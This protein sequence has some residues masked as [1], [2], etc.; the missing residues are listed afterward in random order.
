MYFKQANF[1]GGLDRRGEVCYNVS[2]SNKLTQMI[3]FP[4]W[5]PGCDFDSLALLDFFLSSN[6]S[7]CSTVAFPPLENSD[8][9]IS[10]SIYCLSNSKGDTSF[11]CTAYEICGADRDG[12]HDHLK[13]VPWDDIFKLD[14]SVAASEFCGLVQ[15]GI[16]LYISRRK[17]QIKPYSS[18]WFS[19]ASAAAIA[20]RNHFLSFA[21]TE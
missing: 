11:H 20:H 9:A 17:C 16:D 8:H 2:I 10:V 19:A 15:V 3:N 13:N 5:V 7:V 4:T 6:A 18:A 14:A 21:P 12:L 1:S